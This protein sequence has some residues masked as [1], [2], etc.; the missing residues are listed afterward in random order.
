MCC[1]CVNVTAT[2]EIYTYCHTLSLHDALPICGAGCGGAQ[3]GPGVVALGACPRLDR[4]IVELLQP[5]V[6]I[7]D[8]SPVDEVDHGSGRR[9]RNCRRDVYCGNRNKKGQRKRHGGSRGGHGLRLTL[10]LTGEAILWSN[11]TAF[12]YVV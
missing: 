4:R 6:G 12:L 3:D 8:R 2:T 10:V 9:R 11:C 1:F 7:R 5:A